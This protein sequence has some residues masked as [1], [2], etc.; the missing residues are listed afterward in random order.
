MSEAVPVLIRGLTNSVIAPR[1]NPPPIDL[2]KKDNPVINRVPAA[3]DGWGKRF[4]SRF[5]RSIILALA[6]MGDSMAR[7][8]NM[9]K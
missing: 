7:L 9:F 1:G 3:S 4:A 8:S 2:S 5:R 6:A